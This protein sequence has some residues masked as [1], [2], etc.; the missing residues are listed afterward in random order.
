MELVSV[1]LPAGAMIGVMIG[2]MIGVMI[3]AMLGVMIG[4]LLPAGVRL[5]LSPIQNSPITIFSITTSSAGL[6]EPPFLTLAILSTVPI[7]S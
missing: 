1:S 7:P 5:S 3:G 4:A 6:S 2:A